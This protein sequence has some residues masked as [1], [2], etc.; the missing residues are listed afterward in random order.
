MS[1]HHQHF[2]VQIKDG[3]I[4]RNLISKAAEQHTACP[5]L[6]SLLRSMCPWPVLQHRENLGQQ[7][8]TYSE[9][10]VAEESIGNLRIR[11]DLVRKREP[12][13]PRDCSIEL[14]PAEPTLC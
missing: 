14:T 6:N 3:V 5:A 9:A 10:V 2:T 13:G 4:K 1:T 11:D 7:Q 12:L 8:P